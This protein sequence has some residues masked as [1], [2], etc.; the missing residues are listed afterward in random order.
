M[1][2]CMP[3]AILPGN[4]ENESATG[5]MLFPKSAVPQFPEGCYQ[6]GEHVI[7]VRLILD[8]QGKE[9]DSVLW[10]EIYETDQPLKSLANAVQ[11]RFR[12]NRTKTVATVHGDADFTLT[13]QTDDR[14]EL[15]VWEL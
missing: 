8:C 2:V 12:T 11:T 15:V 1:N 10:F 14:S 7:K 5:N 4:L 3:I 9:F 6:V 13:I